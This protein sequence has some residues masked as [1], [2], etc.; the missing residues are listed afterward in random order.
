[1]SNEP[2]R[3]D[4]YPAHGAVSAEAALIT[5]W[6]SLENFHSDLVV[7][8]GLSIYFHTRNKVDPL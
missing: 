7:V 6:S 8:G 3:F 5:A 4:D 2:S 1:M